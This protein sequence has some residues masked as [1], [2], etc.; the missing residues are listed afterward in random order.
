MSEV[1]AGTANSAARYY[2]DIVRRH[3][4]HAR[5]TGHLPLSSSLPRHPVVLHVDDP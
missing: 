4:E 1:E 5:R 3:E 2:A